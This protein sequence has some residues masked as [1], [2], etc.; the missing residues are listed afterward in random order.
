MCIIV[1]VTRMVKS[2]I[3][4]LVALA[5]A[6]QKIYTKRAWGGAIGW[7]K[8]GGVQWAVTEYGI[9]SGQQP[10]NSKNDKSDYKE[11]SSRTEIGSRNQII[12]ELYGAIT[13]YTLYLYW[14]KDSV[15]KQTIMLLDKSGLRH[16]ST[17]PP[18]PNTEVDMGMPEDEFND[19]LKS[20]GFCTQEKPEDKAERIRKELNKI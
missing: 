4:S 2:K 3:I 12:T 7:I 13:P 10:N 18:D 6:S 14:W 19:M 16:K 11:Y 20:F 15:I 17:I 8:L 9:P 5:N 1:D